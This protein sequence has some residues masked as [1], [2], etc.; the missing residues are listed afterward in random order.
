MNPA[1]QYRK[2]AAEFRSKAATASNRYLAAQWE[3]LAKCYTRLA[4]QADRNSFQD[5]WFEF[6]PKL[7]R[8]QGGEA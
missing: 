3:N 4:E 5:L 7:R 2:K 1:E 8:G 6:G